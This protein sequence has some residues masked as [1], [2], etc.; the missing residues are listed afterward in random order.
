MFVVF[1]LLLA[2]IS[3]SVSNPN[4]DYLYFY[5]LSYIILVIIRMPSLYSSKTNYLN[6]EFW[7]YANLFI[8]TYL[9]FGQ[10]SQI[11]GNIAFAFALGPLL[12]KIPFFEH[13]MV[14]HSLERIST[15]FMHLSPAI[16][17]WT[18]RMT[19]Y[20]QISPLSIFEYI[21][22]SLGGYLIW[23]ITYYVTVLILAY[24]RCKKYG[25]QTAYTRIMNNKHYFSYRFCGYFGEKYS[26]LMY[27][28]G[29]AIFTLITIVLSYIALNFE[30]IHC[31]Y[32]VGILIISLWKAANYY[33]DVFVKHYEVEVQLS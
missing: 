19:N 33:M 9:F 22:Y 14:F 29:H 10:N 11:V 24:D 2:Y 3:F 4:Q 20:V 18:L 15:N 13:G 28:L 26:K 23:L 27:C 16:A 1:S 25:H 21:L 12:L 30:A 31:I 5:P 6:L 8:L 7:N 17:F 32:V